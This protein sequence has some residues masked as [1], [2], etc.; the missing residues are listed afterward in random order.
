MLTLTESHP[1]VVVDVSKLGI[2]IGVD[3]F[4]CGVS[5]HGVVIDVSQLSVVVDVSLR[6]VVVDVSQ[7]GVV[8]DVFQG[9]VG[10]VVDDLQFWLSSL[11]T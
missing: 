7:L 10:W 8:V 11:S 4:Q 3:V 9:V 6:G 2:G 5:Q 1:C